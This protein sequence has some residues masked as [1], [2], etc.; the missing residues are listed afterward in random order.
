MQ[1]YTHTWTCSCLFC[2]AAWTA[3]YVESANPSDLVGDMVR[4]N[5][6]VV[7]RGEI[8][9]LFVER[10]LGERDRD[11]FRLVKGVGGGEGEGRLHDDRNED[12]RK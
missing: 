12:G 1:N 5:G 7:L 11:M 2:K 8:D 9:L 3:E 4:R 10:P 6:D